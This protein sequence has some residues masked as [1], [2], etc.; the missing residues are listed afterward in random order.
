MPQWWQHARMSK[1]TISGSI[2]LPARQ[3]FTNAVAIVGLDDVTLVDAPSRRIAETVIEPVDGSLERIPFRLETQATFPAGKAY[4]LSAEI[5]RSGETRIGPGDFVT[6]VAV[7]WAPG[8]AGD[9]DVPVS[10]I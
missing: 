5:R 10:R 3:S 7:P 1:T 4:V 2:R 6:T 9:T 8:A